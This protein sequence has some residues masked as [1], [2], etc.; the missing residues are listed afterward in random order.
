[1]RHL[2]LAKLPRPAPGDG[3]RLERLVGRVREHGVHVGGLHDG[4]SDAHRVLREAREGGR[5]PSPHALSRAHAHTPAAQQGALARV[6]S[7]LKK[8]VLQRR[9]ERWVR[10]GTPGELDRAPWSHGAL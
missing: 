3:D 6:L 9:K 5:A 8:Q 4:R 7:E 2:L 1:M 10:G